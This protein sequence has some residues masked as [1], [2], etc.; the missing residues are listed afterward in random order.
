[1]PKFKNFHLT[2]A[3]EWVTYTPE[4]QAIMRSLGG[5]PVNNAFIP[6]WDRAPTEKREMLILFGT[7]GSSKTTDRI[8]EHILLALT[9]PYFK[10][11]Y[12][13]QVFEQAK[14]ELH[15]S[16]VSTIKDM[17]F[18]GLFEFS[19]KPNGAKEISCIANG[20]K[21]KPFG[22]D[23]PSSMKGWDNA[24]H[25]IVDELNEIEWKAW[26]MLYTRLR[27]RGAKK[28]F[29]GMFNNC[30]VYDD[31]W[32]RTTLLNKEIDLMDEKGK[33]I[34]RNIIEHFSI[35]TD[36]YF[37]DH[38]DYKNGLIEQAGHD[39]ERRNAYLTGAWGVK[40]TGQ[41]FYKN[42]NQKLH[43][44]YKEYNPKLALHATFDENVNPYL[45]VSIWQV[46]GKQAYCIWELAAK[47]PFNTL[48]WVCNE[49]EKIFGSNGYR[50]EGAFYIYGDATSRKDDTK[51]E[52]GKDFFVL[53]KEYLAHFNPKLRVSKSNPNVA[54]RGNFINEVL[55]RNLY[56][57]FITIST[58]CKNMIGDLTHTSEAPDG[59][60]KDKTKQTVDGIRGV[61][62]HG[63]FSDGGDYFLCEVWMSHF[64]KYKNGGKKQTW[65]FVPRVAHNE[66]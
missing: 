54:L 41:P 12:G 24:T 58:T 51:L 49:I 1:M 33:P 16:I 15:S 39:L 53:A 14:K 60:G 46:D 44:A 37:I 31:H 47:N 66:F 48:R 23:D 61:Q 29:T 17:G 22:C 28:C 3:S 34:E 19:E 4:V 65:G 27:K 64:L 25:I 10:C 9:E 30:D 32:I 50:H 13:R 21:F 43:V 36:N 62:P 18:E 5:F 57:L 56:G 40:T 11:F 2:P 52:K 59:N 7:Y 35:Y 45:P 20:N 8:Q 63:H 55:G 38:E 42:F 26:G 6:L